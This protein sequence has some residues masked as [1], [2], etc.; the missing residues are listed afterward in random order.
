MRGW[1]VFLGKEA[2]E[3]AR[4]WRIWVLPGLLLFL[5]VTSPLVAWLMPSLLKSVA[6]QQ[7][8]VHIQLPPPTSA[9]AYVQ[10]LKNLSQVALW[11][12]IIAAG[13]LVSSEKRAGTAVL[14]LT[15]PI[16]R[17][18][19]VLAKAAAAGGL[20]VLA[21]T[22]GALACWGETYALFGTAPLEP[23][24]AATGAWLAFAL[25]MTAVTVMLSTVIDSPVGA[26]GAG[27]AVYA[28]LALSSL[29]P[30]LARY[31][32]AGLLGAPGELLAGKSPPLLWPLAVS[33]LLAV[34]CLA[35]AT[36]ALS[37]RE[38]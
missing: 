7:P 2:Q 10:W 26:A 31:G 37:R 13:G 11:A 9:D 27:L 8:G 17:A 28:L 29:W 5:G 35:G 24:A 23:F 12:S 22:A 3:T 19:F 32:A 21:T 30:P 4:T 38:L 6:N 34:A 33:A 14:V 15:K 25:L 18:A 16:S 36:A 1:T 20:L